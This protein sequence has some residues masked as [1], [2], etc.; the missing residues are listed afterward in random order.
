MHTL[1]DRIQT[2][3]IQDPYL[4]AMLNIMV[5]GAWLQGRMNLLLK[6]FG[7]SE[8]QYNVLRIL[9]GQHP[10][11]MNLY[12][13]GERMVYPTSNVSRIIDKLFEKRLVSRN[14]CTENRRRVDIS[15]TPAGL[16]LLVEIQ[17]A[18]DA[19][20]RCFENRLS[21]YDVRH[22]SNCLETLRQDK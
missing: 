19:D 5:T 22:L 9:R 14:I 10:Q 6:P 13:I 8:P 18:L 3:P 16:A 2:K 17:P 21:D 12:V 1:E 20:T 4:R 11:S 15:I 7:L